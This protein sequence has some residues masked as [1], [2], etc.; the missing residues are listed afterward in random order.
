MEPYVYRVFAA[1]AACEPL[2]LTKP[3]AVFASAKWAL[4]YALYMGECSGVTSK[5]DRVKLENGSL[6]EEFT[7]DFCTPKY[8]LF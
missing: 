8:E 7:T 4:D 2:V 5:L 1:P 3:T 6:F